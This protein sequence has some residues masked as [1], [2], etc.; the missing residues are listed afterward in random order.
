MTRQD[1]RDVWLREEERTFTGWDFSYIAD[2]TSEQGMEW[3]YRSIVQSYLKPDHTLLDM[4][5]GGGELLLSLSPPSGRTYA[6]ESYLPNYELC[7]KRLPIHG[8]TVRHVTDDDILPFADTFFDL[9]INRQASFDAQEVYRVLKPGGLFITQQVGGQ[10]NLALTHRL[11]GEETSRTTD[12]AFSLKSASRQ[13]LEAGFA[14]RDGKECYP[15][16]RFYDVGALVY[17]AKIIEWE[18]PGF[19][20]ERYD[21][22]LCEMQEDV[23]NIGYVESREHRFFILATKAEDGGT[24]DR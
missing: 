12:P 19:S 9:V 22:R 8:I 1:M 15:I 23:E 2:R 24:H 17:Y 6:T 11:I 21:D 13:L 16:L 10:N 18:F 5:T 4:G 7:L 3:D 20:V 14:I